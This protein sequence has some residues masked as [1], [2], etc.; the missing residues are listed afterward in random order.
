MS[1]SCKVLIGILLCYSVGISVSLALPAQE[2]QD[3][4]ARKPVNSEFD[5]QFGAPL[6]RNE[7]ASRWAL[8]NS[9]LSLEVGHYV[10]NQKE[11]WVVS[12]GDPA[13]YLQRG[14]WTTEPILGDKTAFWDLEL[15][16]KNTGPLNQD[17]NLVRLDVFDADAV[18]VIASRN[19]ARREWK[20]TDENL[21]FTL[22]FKIESSNAG[23]RIE[24]RVY[25]YGGSE[26]GVEEVGYITKDQAWLTPIVNIL[27]S[28]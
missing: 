20:K 8:P 16:E 24:F 1:I 14:P 13:G 25:S 17:R 26:V 22:P 28:D 18:R 12:P 10:G 15:I 2:Y 23:H 19:V 4:L 11:E 6:V 27:L 3:L 5:C 7:Q 9:A 21:C